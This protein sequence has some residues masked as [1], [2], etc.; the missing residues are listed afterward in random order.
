MDKSLLISLK[1]ITKK[2][3]SSA[4]ASTEDIEILKDVDFD[5]YK[6]E[7]IAVIGAEIEFRKRILGVEPHILIMDYSGRFTNYKEII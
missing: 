4:K 2:F 6:G 7:T 3:K 1:S 5:I